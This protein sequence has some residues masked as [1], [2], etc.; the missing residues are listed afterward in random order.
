MAGEKG[1]KVVDRNDKATVLSSSNT[2]LEFDTN[3]RRHIFQF[4]AI[5]GTVTDFIFALKHSIDDGNNFCFVDQGDE[6]LL[7]ENEGIF[8][9]EDLLTDVMKI[10][11]ISGTTDPEFE[12]Y[13]RGIRDGKN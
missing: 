7:D 4:K 10:E 12:I 2:E 6:I 8:I 9:I 5:S 1:Q 11:Y 13:Y 3:A